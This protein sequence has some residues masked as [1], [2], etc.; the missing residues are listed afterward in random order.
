MKA[1]LISQCFGLITLEVYNLICGKLNNVFV[2]CHLVESYCNFTDLISDKKE[3]ESALEL[4][5]LML[6]QQITQLENNA[7]DLNHPWDP[8]AFP[9]A[10]EL[11]AKC[12]NQFDSTLHRPIMELIH[13]IEVVRCYYPRNILQLTADERKIDS[14]VFTSKMNGHSNGHSNG[15]NRRESLSIF[16]QFSDDRLSAPTVVAKK[17]N[18]IMN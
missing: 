1:E 12:L 3:I 18:I 9:L 13:W 5:V 15:G 4:S 2:T 17:V 16:D 10:F 11:L 7:Y 8:L 14:S 6:S